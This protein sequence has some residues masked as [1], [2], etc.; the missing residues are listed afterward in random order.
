MA[1][2]HEAETGPQGAF[3]LN[4]SGLSND[5]LYL[6][7]EDFLDEYPMTA[8]QRF[9]HRLE[10]NGKRIWKKFMELPLWKQITIVAFCST[11]ST[12]GLVAVTFHHKIL[13][14]I[15]KFSNELYALWYMP[16]VFFLLIFVVSFPP[17]VGFSLLCTSVGLVY[18]VSLQGW[19]IISLGTVL[20]SIASFVVF[21]TVLHS[22]AERLV[23]LNDK[24]DAL[25]SILRDNNSYWIIALI[26]L[27]PVP[28]SL[29]NGAMA[30]IYGISVRN[31]SI[32]Q[33]LTTPK[34]V[35]YLFIGSR[36]KN[37][38]ESESS[39]TVFFDIISIFMAVSILVGTASL[40]YY[41]TSRRYQE[42]QRRNEY[43]LP[44]TANI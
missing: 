17:M 1:G 7:D 43:L 33:V 16:L 36:I 30:G 6:D 3:N 31:F 2:R 29:T 44:L 39:F 24:F 41:K 14:H 25:A 21:K 19:V 8:R 12:L 40:L 37:I 20:G 15:I 32:A 34:S 4:N 10:R 13:Q 35:M 42:L 11:V 9:L 26:K 5:L 22:Y 28:Y 27:C 18:G 23:R 38:G